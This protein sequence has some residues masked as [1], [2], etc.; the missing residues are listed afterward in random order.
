[1]SSE[2]ESAFGIF[3]AYM[4]AKYREKEPKYGQSWLTCS[5][6][7][8]KDHIKKHYAHLL[9]SDFDKQDLTGIGL[10]CM[11]LLWRKWKKRD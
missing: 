9:E 5:E 7:I 2:L 8:L 6:D 11:F 3:K 1:M 10:L 4:I